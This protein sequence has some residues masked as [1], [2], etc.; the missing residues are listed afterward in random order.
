M[1]KTI[2][3]K[4]VEIPGVPDT[5]IETGWKKVGFVRIPYPR[6]FYKNVTHILWLVINIPD[7][8]DFSKAIREAIIAGL[9]SGLVAAYI[10]SPGSSIAGF[11][12]GFWGALAVSVGDKISE[13]QWIGV[14]DEIEKDKKWRPM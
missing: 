1:A 6:V 2:R 4:I 11:K 7:T 8:G 3:E 9:A 13:F 10:S 5:K 14:D 12:V